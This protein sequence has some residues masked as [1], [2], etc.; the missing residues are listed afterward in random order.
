MKSNNVTVRYHRGY[1]SLSVE[2][3]RPGIAFSISVIL[4]L[5]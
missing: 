2:I 1:A 5:I 4:A 3:S